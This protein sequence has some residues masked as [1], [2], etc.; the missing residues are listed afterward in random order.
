MSNNAK[1]QC[2]KLF[3]ALRQKPLSTLEARR[4][5]DILHPAA[6][7]QE[8]K[9]AGHNIV[10]HWSSERSECGELHR[11]ARYVLLSTGA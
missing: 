3:Q 11:V 10:T 4:E 1:A 5:L 6:R 8:L 7:V 2:Q 9:A